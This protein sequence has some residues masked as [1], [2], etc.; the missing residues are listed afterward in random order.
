[1]NDGMILRVGIQFSVP[2]FR[3][4]GQAHENDTTVTRAV[5]SAD[6]AF[7]DMFMGNYF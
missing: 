4:Q 1:M 2:W 5:V 6:P 7:G 3:H